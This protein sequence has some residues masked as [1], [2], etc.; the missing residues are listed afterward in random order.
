ML[1]IRGEVVRCELEWR[2]IVARSP[3]LRV[4][5]STGKHDESDEYEIRWEYGVLAEHE[6]RDEL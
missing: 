6:V 3:L 1:E 5:T 2:L 4:R